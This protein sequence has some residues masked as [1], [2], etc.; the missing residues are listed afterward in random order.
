MLIDDVRVI[1]T[2]GSFSAEIAKYYIDI[3]R[4]SSKFKLKKVV[5][6]LSDTYLDIRC[7]FASIP[8]ERIERIP[9]TSLPEDRAVNN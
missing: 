1:I 3:I 5:F 4:K 8:F 7:T 6:T 2:K 9:L